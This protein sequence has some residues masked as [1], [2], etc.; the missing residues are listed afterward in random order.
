MA[1]IEIEKKFILSD[2]QKEALLEDAE[3]VGEA[4]IEDSYLDTE[5]YDLT[6]QDYWFRLRDGLY[7]LKAPLRSGAGSY[8]GTNRY[9][10]LTDIDAISSEL[11]LNASNEIE[12]NLSESGIKPFITCFTKRKSY[13]KEG[14]KID[15]DTATY[16]NSDF[17]YS[18]AE[19]ELLVEDESEA[20][21]AEERI[22]AFAKKYDL[23]TDQIILGKIAAYLK[24]ENPDHYEKLVAAGVLK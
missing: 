20:D 3:S 10:E 19:I 13:K 9:R 8:E 5:S 18:V 2:A 14:F 15:I 24:E 7:E 17:T 23:S 6:L 11:G 22:I 16:E 12:V 1:E 21:A 4:T